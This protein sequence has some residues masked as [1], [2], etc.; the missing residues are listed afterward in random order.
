MNMM[1]EEKGREE[2][3]V[4]GRE[5]G[6]EDLEGGASGEAEEEGISGANQRRW[7]M[8]EILWWMMLEA[9]MHW[10]RKLDTVYMYLGALNGIVRVL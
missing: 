7:T 4:G 8:R 9:E 6:D 3:G 5:V 1:I 2:E 10:D